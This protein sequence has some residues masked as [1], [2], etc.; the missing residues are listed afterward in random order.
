L[1]NLLAIRDSV[2]RRWIWLA[3]LL[4]LAISVLWLSF[5]AYQSHYIS[6]LRILGDGATQ[7]YFGE[8]KEGR[9][10]EWSTYLPFLKQSYLEGF[11][12]KSS[13]EPYKEQFD[14]F[15][16]LPSKSAAL[17][18]LPNQVAY[19]V[20]PGW[21]SLSFQGL[22][23]NLLLLVSAVWFLRNLGIRPGIACSAAVVLLFS[24]LYQVWWTSNFA[25]LGASLLPFAIWTS[26]IRLKWSAPLL[27]WSIGHMLLGQ[28]YPPFYFSIAVALV[29]FAVAARP[30]LLRLRA[31]AWCGFWVALAC[32]AVLYFKLDYIERVSGTSYPGM[33]V[34]MGGDA[35]FSSLLGVLFPTYPASSEIDVGASLYELSVVGTFFTLLGVAALP[36]VDW[37]RRVVRVSLVSLAVMCVLVV[38]MLH[39]FPESLAKIS[40]FFMAPGR[41]IQLGFSV[42]VL[43]LSAFLVSN[44]KA[45]IKPVSLVAVFGLYALLASVAPERVDAVG[46]FHFYRFYPVAGIALLMLGGVVALLWDRGRSAANMM[47]A[48]LLVLMPG[49]HIFIFGSFNPVMDASAILRPVNS[50]LMRD[51]RALH[52]LAG[53][54]SLGVVGNYGHLL[55]GEGVPALE[56]I[57]LVNVDP[58]VY[59][60]VFPEVPKA[61]RERV[62]NQFRGISFRN[63]PGYDAAGLTAFF[64]LRPHSV[65]FEH[66]IQSGGVSVSLLSGSAQ[67]THVERKDLTRYV[68]HWQGQLRQPVPIEQQLRLGLT[69][70]VQGSWLTRYPLGGGDLADGAVALQGVA[71]EVTVL[72]RSEDAARA[73][74]ATV[75]VS[76]VGIEP[77]IARKPELVASEAASTGY[78]DG[79]RWSGKACDLNAPESL[80]VSRETPAVLSGYAISS[81]DKP[82]GDFQLFLRGE[83]VYK[84]AAGTGSPRP[85]VADYFRNPGLVNSGYEVAVDLQGVRPGSYAIEYLWTEPLQRSFCETGKS[86]TVE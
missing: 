71:G 28:F 35:S 11:P 78:R 56:A 69:C 55:R 5:G 70:K 24:H 12:Q 21:L 82:A 83:Q 9:G 59:D 84:F 61:E 65:A 13:L 8:A 2:A 51:W 31:A 6:G 73:C 67:V 41:R 29:P 32:A 3:G 26:S 75:S 4:L 17:L 63:A 44:C 79:A 76:A 80:R 33:R 42:L 53:R 47:L 22:Y 19:F 20:L 46:Q 15:I 81:S 30:E 39:G 45:P 62:F 23:Y 64:S 37:T 66:V 27:G 72:A 14:W 57:H 48:A 68:V 77:V 74:V 34:S 49:L 40:G 52:A 1:I 38:Y 58:E 54:N 25:A 7:S 50:Q 86:I 60:S 16:T 10:D 18:L 43:F 85:D 36:Y